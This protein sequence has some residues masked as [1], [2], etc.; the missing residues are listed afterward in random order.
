MTNH[1]GQCVS[2]YNQAQL[3]GTAYINT[4]TMQNV[5]LGFT[6]RPTGLWP[7][8]PDIFSAE[9][10]AASQINEDQ[11]HTGKPLPPLPVEDVVKPPSTIESSTSP[12]VDVPPPPPVHDVVEPS[13]IEPSLSPSVEPSTPRS[14]RGWLKSAVELVGHFSPIPQL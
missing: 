9:D 11:D 14:A 6:C 13:A 10:F 4:A 5:I 12:A 8:N 2:P 7:Y 3:F 1:V